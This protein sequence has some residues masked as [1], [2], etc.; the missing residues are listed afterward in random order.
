MEV[1]FLLS[2][3][4]LGVFSFF[5]LVCVVHLYVSCIICLGFVLQAQGSAC[6][7]DLI[8]LWGEHISDSIKYPVGALYYD[9]PRA[10]ID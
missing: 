7:C 5:F 8:L 9:A 6:T 4:F 3:R 1:Y 10:R 2:V